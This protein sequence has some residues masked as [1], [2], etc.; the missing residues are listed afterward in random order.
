MDARFIRPLKK[1]GKDL[2]SFSRIDRDRVARFFTYL[3]RYVNM[4]MDL[5]L[6]LVL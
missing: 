5:D 4:D 3:P 6:D 2:C 1:M